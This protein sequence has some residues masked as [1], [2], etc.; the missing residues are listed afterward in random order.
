[1]Q[2]GARG[3]GLSPASGASFRLGSG[4][5]PRAQATPSNCCLSQ[6]RGGVW[7]RHCETSHPRDLRGK[8]KP[9]A[10]GTDT[11]NRRHHQTP[12][13]FSWGNSTRGSPWLGTVVTSSAR[14][15]R[16][17]ENT[18]EV[19]V[20]REFPTSY[21]AKLAV[22]A[23]LW[24]TGGGHQRPV[25]GLAAC[26]LGPWATSRRLMPPLAP[27]PSVPDILLRPSLLLAC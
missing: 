24:G 12:S 16:P 18:A 17:C 1:M 4:P 7:P 3:E 10:T 14:P 26:R 19:C 5:G 27:P 9:E 21:P 6:V 20:G 13:C 2:Q 11:L 23:G 8:P 25:G 22:P 15:P